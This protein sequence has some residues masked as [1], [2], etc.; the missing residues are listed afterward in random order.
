[1][2]NVKLC[3]GTRFKSNNVHG[4]N[5]AGDGHKTPIDRHILRSKI[6][7]VSGRREKRLVIE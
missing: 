7:D 6:S 3:F 1:M 4:D 2:R 5:A